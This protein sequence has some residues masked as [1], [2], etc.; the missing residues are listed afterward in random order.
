MIEKIIKKK[1]SDK[2]FITIVL[3]GGPCGGKSSVKKD[4]LEFFSRKGVK[5]FFPEEQATR[6]M[7]MGIIPGKTISYID[8]QKLLLSS[9]LGV[10][11]LIK[12]Y[13]TND[14]VILVCDRGMLDNKSYVIDEEWK[15]LLYELSLKEED[16]YSRYDLIMHL[17]TAAYGAEKFYSNSSTENSTNAYRKESIEEARRADDATRKAYYGAKNVVYFGNETDF[18]T[19]KKRVIESIAS[20]VGED[21]PKYQRRFI[22]KRPN[23]NYLKGKLSAQKRDIS[24]IYLVSNESETER[25]VRA[26]GMSGIYSYYYTSKRRIDGIET[27]IEDEKI[28]PSEYFSYIKECDNEC[29]IINKERWYFSHNSLALQLDMYNELNGLSIL[30]VHMI[31]E[32]DEIKLPEEFEVLFEITGDSRYTNYNISKIARDK[33]KLGIL[34]SRLKLIYDN[35]IRKEVVIIPHD[36]ADVDACISCILLEKLLKFLGVKCCYK[37]TGKTAD[38]FTQDI[39]TILNVKL[40]YGE[41][42]CKN[43]LI[44]VD[45]YETTHSGNVI[46]CIDHHPIL[47]ELN[48]SFVDENNI[49]STAAV[50]FRYMENCGYPISKADVEMLAYAMCIDT[51]SFRSKKAVAGEKEWLKSYLEKYGLN[52]TEFEKAG[53]QVNDITSMNITQIV[54]NGL[55]KYIFYGNTVYASYVMINTDNRLDEKAIWEYILQKCNTDGIKVWIFIKYMVDINL[56][57]IYYITNEEIVIEHYDGIVSRGKEIMPRV[58]EFLRNQ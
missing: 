47:K 1:S 49:S 48:Y 34:T 6:F 24:Q 5:V 17:V 37:I 43:N 16:I 35:V 21:V 45:H 7:E 20:Y 58:E 57:V 27:V 54:T 32:D 44:L 12:E 30:E 41:T 38:K 26:Y 55:K 51:T 52:Y 33:K 10:E 56:S 4:I 11:E 31:R 9:Q 42:S 15:N 40:H 25:R 39:M 53:I 46:G 50:I 22:I 29:S 23:A 14:K 2:Y 18:E 13:Y 8:F 28:S 36:N 19:K 3:T